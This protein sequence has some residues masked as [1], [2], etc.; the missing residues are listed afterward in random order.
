MVDVKRELVTIIHA[1]LPGCRI[2]LFGSRARGTHEQGADYDLAL[3]AGQ[4]IPFRALM[5]IQGMIDDSKVPVFVD[6]V[7]LN[8]APSALL[9]QI[10]QDGIVWI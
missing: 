10:E 6:L 8:K 3:D 1:V 4:P 7:D 2:I 9:Q 5:T